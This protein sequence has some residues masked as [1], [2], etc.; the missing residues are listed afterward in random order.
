[1]PI[2]LPDVNVLNA[3]TDP[4]HANH[5]AASRWFAQASPHGWATCALTENGLVRI[6]TS[7]AY[8]GLSLRPVDTIGLLETLLRN[9]AASHTFWPDSVSLSDRTLFRPEKVAGHRQIND[10]YLLGLCQR[11]AGTL[12]TFDATIPV[13]A[14]VSPHGALVRQL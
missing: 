8:P 9:H 7:P 11:H 3:M 13:D 4:L 5:E 12:V 14:I 6:L 1:V 10:V 2:E